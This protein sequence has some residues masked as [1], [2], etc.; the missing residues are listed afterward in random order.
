[1]KR[2]IDVATTATLEFLTGCLPDEA[3]V[4]EVGCGD[5]LV[6]LELARRGYDVLAIDADEEAVELAR[7]NGVP[8]IHADWVEF[9][10]SPADAIAFTRS[11]HHIHA[12]ED[13]IRKA[14]DLLVPGGLL[15][16]EDFAVEAV[17]EKSLNWFVGVLNSPLGN[18]LVNPASDEFLSDLMNGMD[19]LEAWRRSHDHDLHSFAD[20]NLAISDQFSNQDAWPVPYLYRYL[21]DALPETPQATSFLESIAGE[22][23]SGGARRVITML[24]RRIV[25]RL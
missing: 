14:V 13:A 4:L 1:M 7:E 11:L 3:S 5:G 20:M 23:A 9:D 6:A 2:P 8:A 22:E 21:V 10:C 16:V 19:P 18:A 24:G 17:D 25:A 12:L 15:L